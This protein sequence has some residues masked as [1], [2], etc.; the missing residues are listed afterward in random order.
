MSKNTKD[1][2]LFVIFICAEPVPWLKSKYFCGKVSCR[3]YYYLIHY[4]ILKFESI[5]KFPNHIFRKWYLKNFFFEQLFYTLA[6]SGQKLQ[7][8]LVPL[9]IQWRSGGRIEPTEQK[10]RTQV[11]CDWFFFLKFI[12]YINKTFKRI[13][14]HELND[15]HKENLCLTHISNIMAVWLLLTFFICLHNQLSSVRSIIT[16]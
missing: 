9:K 10:R 7:V 8:Q 6:D 3:W 1:I 14:F 11:G 13:L 4:S 15:T 12:F 16:Y 2:S 5:F